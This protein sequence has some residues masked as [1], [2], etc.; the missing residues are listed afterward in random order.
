MMKI[1]SKLQED[2]I[3]ELSLIDKKKLVIK[4]IPYTF[5]FYIFN[6]LGQMYRW[7]QSDNLFVTIYQMLIHS[8]ELFKPPWASYYIKDIIT[9][10]TGAIAVYLI[11]YS[12]GKNARKYRKGE[13]YGS[14]RWGNAK[15]I[16]TYID[17]IYEENILLTQTE[18]LMMNGRPK[19][20]KHARNK[21]VMVVGGS[22]SGKTRFYV[23]PNLMQMHSSYVVTD[24]KGT[25]LL[26]CGKLLERGAPKIRMEEKLEIK[27]G[28]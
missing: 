14:A 17:P 27:E 15:D 5:I 26:E 18:R 11:V 3:Y 8:G 2:I 9:G 25:I 12:K 6:K 21:N 4:L 24:P 1:I 23:K 13:E 28:K 22:G 10:L 19:N 20:P 7:L 16:R